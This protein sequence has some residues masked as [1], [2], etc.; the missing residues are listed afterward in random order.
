M[1][2]IFGII[3]NEKK[4]IT[5][6]CKFMEDMTRL[7]TLRGKDSTGF[8]Q[9]KD[10]NDVTV[11]KLPY[12]GELVAEHQRAKSIFNMADT[13][14][15]TIGH[16]RAATRGAI[17]LDNCHPFEHWNKEKY[18]VGVHNGYFAKWFTKEDGIPFEV[19]SDWGLYRIFRDGAV[20]AMPDLTGAYALV[21]Y[22]NDGKIRIAANGMREF[23]FAF[24]ADKNAMVMASEHSMLYCATSRNNIKLE[25]TILY[26][27]ADTIY[28][29][30]P[31]DVRAFTKEKF[32]V[33]K[34]EPA[35]KVTDLR[36]RENW[37][38]R[39]WH[40]MASDDSDDDLLNYGRGLGQQ[41]LNL[42]PNFEIDG[43]KAVFTS[44]EIY[45]R[46]KINMGETLE[47]F[48]D[49]TGLSKLK[50]TDTYLPGYVSLQDDDVLPAIMTDV[51][52]HIRSNVL[53]ANKDTS[54]VECRVIGVMK[55]KVAGK[56]QDVAVLSK[57]VR[58]LTVEDDA[59]ASATITLGDA[60]TIPGPSGVLLTPDQ[61]ISLTRDGCT[62]C[63][64]SIIPRDAGKIH[65][66]RD[67]QTGVIQPI[68]LSCATQMNLAVG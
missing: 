57:P 32:E 29:F 14:Q 51:T 15:I 18:L 22:E 55:Y 65:W 24:V 11:F 25:N 8:F 68:C 44:S 28:A 37:N 4:R 6:L 10:L 31:K 64:G 21:W 49:W 36:R 27:S 63:T 16:H 56:L 50:K 46:L 34:Y 67:N 20:K 38:N 58:I 66:D 13:H 41:G 7:G 30:D 61:F 62:M 47:F 19:D 5:E 2:G 39:G 54:I 42:S 1:C 43:E 26:P 45:S 59:N 17:S 48:P 33:P 23:H 53:A 40:G 12:S 9:V 60:A 3:Q 35:T 52:P